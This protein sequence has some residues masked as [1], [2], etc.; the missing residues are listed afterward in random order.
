MCY[1]HTAG[2]VSHSDIKGSVLMSECDI[3][4]HVLLVDKQTK[5]GYKHWATMQMIRGT[6]TDADAISDRGR[7]C[8]EPMHSSP[9]TRPCQGP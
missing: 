4:T 5:V 6:S 7:A 2:S 3:K 8:P 1:K 9:S